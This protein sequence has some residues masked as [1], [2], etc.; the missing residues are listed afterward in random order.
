[1]NSLLRATL[2]HHR[3]IITAWYAC[4]LA[5]G[6]KGVKMQ[7]VLSAC[8]LRGGNYRSETAVGRRESSQ[9]NRCRRVAAFHLYTVIRHGGGIWRQR[10]SH[11]QLS[12]R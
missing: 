8:E 12:N 11:A 1:M 2:L 9:I 6:V 4:F 5:V 7:G 10:Q 3:E